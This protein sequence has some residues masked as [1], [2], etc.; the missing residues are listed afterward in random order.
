MRHVKQWFA[1]HGVMVLVWSGKSPYLNPIE[2]LCEE[3]DRRFDDRKYAKLDQLMCTLASEWKKI[4]LDRIT[5]LVDSITASC[6][7]VIAA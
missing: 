4:P 2:H 7:A 5:K 1:D 3:L 6:Q